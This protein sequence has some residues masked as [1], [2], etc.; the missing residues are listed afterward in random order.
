MFG[1]SR[2]DLQKIQKLQELHIPWSI[3]WSEWQAE[4]CITYSMRDPATLESVQCEMEMNLQIGLETRAR[5]QL[6]V[7]AFI[8]FLNKFGYRLEPPHPGYGL[9]WKISASI[10]LAGLTALSRTGPEEFLQMTRQ[11]KNRKEFL[12]LKG[13]SLPRDDETSQS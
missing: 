5:A 12:V 13:F 9:R 7:L 11:A 3:E 2:D 6:S 4:F 10:F 1:L 8:G